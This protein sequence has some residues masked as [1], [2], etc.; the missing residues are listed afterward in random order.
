[1]SRIALSPLSKRLTTSTLRT[2]TKLFKLE[3]GTGEPP[4]FK[5]PFFTTFLISLR[6]RELTK[7]TSTV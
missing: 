4:V 6:P 1:M 7:G 2:S 5:A 3:F